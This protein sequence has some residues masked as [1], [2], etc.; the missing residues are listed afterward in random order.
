MRLR[1]DGSGMSNSV[2]GVFTGGYSSP[3]LVPFMEYVTISTTGNGTRFGDLTTDTFR[4]GGH[5]SPVRGVVSG[6][7]V[8]ASPYATLD[9]L[10]SINFATEG[11]TVDFGDL[12]KGRYEH[13]SISNA[14]GGLG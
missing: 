9:T 1:G 3:G 11:D 4:E 14:H 5:A 6:G 2:R 13:A 8:P 7:M 12:S 10:Q